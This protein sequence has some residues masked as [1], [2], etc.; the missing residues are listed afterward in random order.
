[1]PW[2]IAGV[3]VLVPVLKHSPVSM[4]VEMEEQFERFWKV[5]PNRRGSN[6]K[7]LA[8]VKFIRCVTNGCDPEKII[9]AAQQWADDETRNKKVG[10]E[11][12]P[13]AQTWLN[14]RRFLDFDQAPEKPVFFPAYPGSAEFNAWKSYYDSSGQ[15]HMVSML[16]V[17][18]LEGRAWQ[19]QT[20]WPPQQSG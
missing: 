10:T 9:S 11:F 20:Q 8:R 13:M 17:R 3:V 2:L 4:G 6:P 18:E 12:V 19:F 15:K 7:Y 14:Q 5:K 16:K 1:M